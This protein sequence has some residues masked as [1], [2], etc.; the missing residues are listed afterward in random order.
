MYADESGW[1]R[2]RRAADV[3]GWARV[4]RV[5]CT[6]VAPRATRREKADVT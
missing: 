4:R 1:A 5:G 2:V 3:S 6:A